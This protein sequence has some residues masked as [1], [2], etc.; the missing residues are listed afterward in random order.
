[1]FLAMVG[2][3]CQASGYYVSIRG[4][5]RRARSSLATAAPLEPACQPVQRVTRASLAGIPPKPVE[6]AFT[7]DNPSPDPDN[8]LILTVK[9]KGR[10]LVAARDFEAGEIVTEYLGKKMEWDEG[11]RLDA[12]YK[13][14]G[15]HPTMIFA[16]H[17]TPKFALDGYVDKD[18]NEFG[19]VG[20]PGALLNT[21]MKNP[22]CE[23]YTEG[24]T[25]E[26]TRF[27]LRTR[28]PVA[29]GIEFSWCYNDHRK[30]LEAYIRS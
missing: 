23:L 5:N 21:K 14:Q 17:S 3:L 15:K 29:K 11:V 16:D 9:G 30:G 13:N 2:T 28:R 22:N 1:V 24:T 4:R 7:C 8:Y 25:K 12:E 27:Y 6:N 10:G 20:N 26:D 18:G 19:P